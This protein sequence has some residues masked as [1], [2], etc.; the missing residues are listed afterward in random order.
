MRGR[1]KV[2]EEAIQGIDELKLAF[3]DPDH[4]AAFLPCG[5]NAPAET[6]GSSETIFA[7]LLSYFL[8]GTD[9]VTHCH[10]SYYRQVMLLEN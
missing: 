8:R 6:W 2:A 3:R 10:K 7:T 5:P 1:T 9:S 4:A